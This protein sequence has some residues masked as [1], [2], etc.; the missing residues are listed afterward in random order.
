MILS[1]R[2]L[3]S[4]LLCC[5]VARIGITSAATR[6][7]MLWSLAQSM[8]WPCHT[9]MQVATKIMKWNEAESSVCQSITQA[10]WEFWESQ[11]PLQKVG[12]EP[13]PTVDVQEHLQDLLLH[14]EVTFGSDWRK[15]PLLLKGLWSAEAL[16]NSKRRLSTEG[17]LLEELEV[18]YFTDARRKGAL[19]PDGRAPISRIVANITK[20]GA[21]H[22]IGTQLL[23]QTYPDLINEVA[24]LD[25]VKELFGDH[26]STEAVKGSGP[27]GLPIFPASTTVPVFVASGILAVGNDSNEAAMKDT[28]MDSHSS[29]RMPFTELHC[30][31]IGNIAVQLSGKKKWTLVRPEFSRLLKPSISPDGRAFFA[32]WANDYAHV[33]SYNAVTEAGDAIWVPTWTWHRVDYLPSDEMAIGASLFHFRPVDFVR[34]NPLFGLLIVPAIFLELVGVNTQ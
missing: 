4:S 1:R 27:F 12:E 3:L 33:P 14:L 8:L 17:L 34:N 16:H 22:K 7:W 28:S 5:I 2:L 9:W 13:I 18:P 23:V 20:A 10:A 19:S 6:H 25:T 30:E 15:R 11:R 26:F 21:P 32:S 29:Q 31:P 24:P